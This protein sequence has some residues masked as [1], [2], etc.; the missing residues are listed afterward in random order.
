[1]SVIRLR[2]RL[3]ALPLSGRT[4]SS[5][6]SAMSSTWTSAGPISSLPRWETMRRMKAS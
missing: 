1:L 3:G 2:D 5:A 6:V 4:A